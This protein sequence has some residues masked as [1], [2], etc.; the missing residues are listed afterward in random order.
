LA[1]RYYF[2][3][4]GRLLLKATGKRLKARGQRLR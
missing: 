3:F 4:Q 2:C 1:S